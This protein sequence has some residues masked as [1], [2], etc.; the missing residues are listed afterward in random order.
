MSKTSPKPKRA[1]DTLRFFVA[2]QPLRSPGGALPDTVLC[3]AVT[4]GKQFFGPPIRF[5]FRRGMLVSLR[6]RLYW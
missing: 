6:V 4:A 3:V 5:E 1:V 2:T